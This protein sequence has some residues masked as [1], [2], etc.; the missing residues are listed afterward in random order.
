MLYQ[1]PQGGPAL[2]APEWAAQGLNSLYLMLGGSPVDMTGRYKAAVTGTI[3]IRAA[4]K[5]GLAM[6]FNG[7][8]QQFNTPLG[9]MS[10]GTKFSKFALIGLADNSGTYTIS[11][12]AAST[13]AQFRLNAGNLELVYSGT[14]LV[15]SAA[16]GLAAGQVAV[17]G[18]TYDGATVRV[19][20][21]AREIGSAACT[22]NFTETSID[23]GIGQRFSGTEIYKGQIY[24]H[25]DFNRAIGQAAAKELSANIWQLFF[26][27]EEEDEIVFPAAAGGVNSYSY[28]ASGGMVLSGAITTVRGRVKVASGGIQTGGAASVARGVQRSASGGMTFAGAAS[29]AV[30]KAI[31]ATGGLMFGGAASSVRGVARAATGGIIFAGQAGASFFSAVQSRVVNPVGGIVIAGGALVAR[32]VRKAAAGGITFAGRAAATFFPPGVVTLLNGMLPEFVRR[33]RRK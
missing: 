24:A 27:T 3:P 5:A 11:S 1:Q 32:G 20:A 29:R 21:N 19:F 22:F 4:G 13:G 28:T 18:L 8:T 7:T 26:D 23:T 12:T 2:I 6:S 9:A 30:G 10:S 15:I 17:V 14:A 33:R 16:H 25:A 31:T